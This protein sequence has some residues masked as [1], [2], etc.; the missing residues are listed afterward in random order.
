MAV[1]LLLLLQGIFFLPCSSFL[2]QAGLQD[3]DLQPRPHGDDETT[4]PAASQFLALFRKK[5]DSFVGRR[6]SIPPTMIVNG[7]R[8]E[9]WGVDSPPQ[10]PPGATEAVSFDEHKRRTEQWKLVHEEPDSH[11]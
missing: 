7:Y 9:Q 3:G 6:A 5:L 4:S 1:V 8:T 10:L 2:L 11:T